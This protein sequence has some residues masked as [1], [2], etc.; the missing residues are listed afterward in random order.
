MFSKKSITPFEFKSL[1]VVYPS[2]WLFT[3][4]G[5]AANIPSTVIGFVPIRPFESPSLKPAST[6]SKHP[7]SSLSRSRWLY[8]KSESVSSGK[9]FIDNTPLNTELPEVFS[10]ICL[11]VNWVIPSEW[12]ENLFAAETLLSKVKRIS[13]EVT[14]TVLES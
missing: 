2:P 1:G 6:V 12:N 7:S 3:L 11:K 13:L 9:N 14:V 5:S 10:V 4:P 8:T